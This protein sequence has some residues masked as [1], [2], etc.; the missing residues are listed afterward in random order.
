MLSNIIAGQIFPKNL[1]KA[2]TCKNHKVL[3]LADHYYPA[4]EYNFLGSGLKA[5]TLKSF[6]S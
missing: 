2:R 5:R 3:S 4:T 6:K 1:A